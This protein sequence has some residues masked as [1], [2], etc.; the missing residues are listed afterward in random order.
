[1]GGGNRSRIQ[2]TVNLEIPSH[3]RLPPSFNGTLITVTYGLEVFVK[4]DVWNEWGKGKSAYI[5]IK[6]FNKAHQPSAI[7]Q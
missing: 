7:S 4:H 2:S 3:D 1:M 5:P 6:I